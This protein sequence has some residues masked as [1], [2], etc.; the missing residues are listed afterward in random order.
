M[1]QLLQTT[2]SANDAIDTAVDALNKITIHNDWG[3]KEKN[4]INNYT[5]SNKNKVKNLQEHS[6]SFLNVLSSVSADFETSENKI[7]DMFQSIEGL[8]G[9][10]F[11]TITGTP[12]HTGGNHLPNIQLPTLPTGHVPF[13]PS[14]IGSL[15][16]IDGNIVITP[17]EGVTVENGA[18]NISKHDGVVWNEHINNLMNGQTDIGSG[19]LTQQ[20]VSGLVNPSSFTRFELNSISQNISMCDY[21]LVSNLG[22]ADL[23]SR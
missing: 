21:S 2:A 19:S 8:L 15:N 9:K 14:F 16:I 22:S 6:R 12:A 18:I 17:N 1:K 20:M 13:T 5:T 10:V 4:S 3:C 11:S 7:K 23:G